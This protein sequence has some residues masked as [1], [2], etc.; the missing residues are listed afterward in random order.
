MVLENMDDYCLDAPALHAD[1]LEK[2][3]KG[4]SDPSL[5]D[6]PTTG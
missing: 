6:L 4:A 1:K 2:I 5:L 3:R